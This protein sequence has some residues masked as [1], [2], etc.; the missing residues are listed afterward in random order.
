MEA[1][2]GDELTTS[3][4]QGRDLLTNWDFR[5]KPDRLPLDLVE[6]W[7]SYLL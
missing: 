3:E 4:Q 5:W 2:A 6:L 1:L 7:Q